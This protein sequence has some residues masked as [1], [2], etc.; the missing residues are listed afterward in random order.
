MFFF[1]FP[2]FEFPIYV[3]ITTQLMEKYFQYLKFSFVIIRN[4]NVYAFAWDKIF[5]QEF[6]AIAFP[7]YILKFIYEEMI[8]YDQIFLRIRKNVLKMCSIQ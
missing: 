1:I 8:E 7:D 6:K 2:L 5:G 3:T 4:N